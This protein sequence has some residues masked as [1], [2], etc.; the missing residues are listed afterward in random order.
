M[1]QRFSERLDPWRLVDAEEVIEGE[2]PLASMHRLATVIIAGEERAAF[3]VRFG[4]DD[5]RRGVISTEVRADLTVICQRCMQ[6][7][8]LKLELNSRLALVE[9]LAEAERLPDDL[10][11]LL[12]EEDGLIVIR[13]QIEEELLLAIPTAP[14]HEQACQLDVGGNELQHEPDSQADEK[15]N[16]FAILAELRSTKPDN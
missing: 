6:P 9:G 15:E 10:D 14:K 16:P 13:D 8:S 7:M 5:K 1:L 4:R 3:V 11:P 2:I 12:L